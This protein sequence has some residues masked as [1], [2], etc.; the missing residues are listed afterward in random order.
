MGKTKALE[1]YCFH[2]PAEKPKRTEFINTLEAIKLYCAEKYKNQ[3]RR[4]KTTLFE[5]FKEPTIKQVSKPTD[6][7]A[8][9]YELEVKIYLADYKEYKDEKCEL[10]NSLEGLFDIIMGQCSPLMR[11]KMQASQ[12]FKIMKVNSEV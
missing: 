4:L 3:C 9:D 6:P 12:E 2:I 8:A 7:K 5:D 10:E 1:G 11:V